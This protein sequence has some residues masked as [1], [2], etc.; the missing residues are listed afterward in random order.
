[1]IYGFNNTVCTP[2]ISKEV[3]FVIHYQH[4]NNNYI[5]IIIIWKETLGGD[6]CSSFIYFFLVAKVT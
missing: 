2:N 3:A 1:M 4:K 5:I 6:G